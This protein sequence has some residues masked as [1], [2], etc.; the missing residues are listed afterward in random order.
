ME[1]TSAIM[2][3]FF[4][5]VEAADDFSPL[6]RECPDILQDY[7][8]LAVQPCLNE[9]DADRLDEILD[10]AVSN[11]WLNFWISAVDHLL[12]HRLQLNESTLKE[13]LT[14]QQA[15]LQEM[16][17]ISLSNASSVQE[18]TNILATQ[19]NMTFKEVQQHLLNR[20][21]DPGPLDGVI[22][23]RTQAALKQFQT[24]HRLHPSGQLDV[25]TRHALGLS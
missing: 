16:R 1:L 4:L 25:E 13:T 14:N 8:H 21:F 10:L 12:V 18:L 15:W 6:A 2:T 11:R 3:K 9:V 22:G 20:G 23:S 5:N 19:I 17:Q 24:T 7:L